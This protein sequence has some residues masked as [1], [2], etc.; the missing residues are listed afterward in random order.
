MYSLATLLQYVSFIHNMQQNNRT[1]EISAS[2]VAMDSVVTWPWLFSA[3]SFC[4]YLVRRTSYDRPS[5]RQL[6]F[7]SLSLMITCTA[8]IGTWPVSV[9][10]VRHSPPE[11]HPVLAV[12]R[13]VSTLLRAS[14]RSLPPVVL[15]SLP[16]RPAGGN[17]SRTLIR[18]KKQNK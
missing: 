8:E 11:L 2:G 12:S 13:Q 9:A 3:L 1:A 14:C 15:H 17:T 7:L 4:A 5:L 18:R 16:A 10:Q 6:R